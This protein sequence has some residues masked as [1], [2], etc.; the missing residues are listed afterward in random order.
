MTTDSKVKSDNAISLGSNIKKLRLEHSY[1]QAY[2]VRQMQL[3]GCNTTKQNYSKNEKDL[4]HISA[5][6]LVAIANIFNISID[7]LFTFV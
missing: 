6:E 7:V 2:M 4:A 3:L 5:S 1:T